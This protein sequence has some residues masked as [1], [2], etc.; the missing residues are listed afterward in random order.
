MDP[1]QRSYSRRSLLPIEQQIID[2]LGLTLDEYWEFCRLADCK[3]KE[4]GEEYALIPEAVASAE[5]VTT[6]TYIVVSLLLAAASTAAA[7][8]LAPRPPS[9]DDDQLTPIRTADV[10]GQ[11]KFAELYAFDSLQDLATLGS[12]IPLVFAKQIPDPGLPNKVIGGIRV[13]SLLLWS[14]LLSKGSHQELKMLTT[15]GLSE[16]AATP[17]SQGL[18]IGDQLL[19]NYQDA[20]YRAYFRNNTADGGRILKGNTFAGSLPEEVGDDIFLAFDP[21]V[22]DKLSPFTSGTR[23]PNS[24]RQFGC[25]TPISNGAPYFLPYNLV[26][27]FDDDDSLKAK[28][29]KING[30]KGTGHSRPFSSRQGMHLLVRIDPITQQE[31]SRFEATPGNAAS[32]EIKAGDRMAFM[33]SFT[34]ED[35]DAFEPHGLDDVNSAIAQR[36]SQTDEQINVGDVF[37]FGSSIIQ[38]TRTSTPEPF[39]EGISESKTYDFV[40]LEPGTGH[41]IAADNQPLIEGNA[42]FGMHLQKLDIATVTNNRS[43]DQTEIGIKSVVFKQVS[44]F[45]NV[46]SEPPQRTLEDYESDGQSFQ[47]GRITTFQTR[48]S[49]FSLQV[50]PINSTD[51]TPFVDIMGGSFFAVRGDTPQPQ[52]NTIR[53][54]HPRGQYEFRLLPRSGT[55]ADGVFIDTPVNSQPLHVLDGANREEIG[56]LFEVSYTGRRRNITNAKVTNKEFLFRRVEENTTVTGKVL[57]LN[58][59]S[60]GSLPPGAA[61]KFTN[62]SRAEFNQETGELEYGVFV[63]VDNPTAPGAKFARWAGQTVELGSQYQYDAAPSDIVDTFPAIK[64][65]RVVEPAVL[66]R[67]GPTPHYYVEVDGDGTLISGVFNDIDV[68]AQTQDP[69]LENDFTKLYRVGSDGEEEVVQIAEGIADDPAGPQY[70]PLTVGGYFGVWERQVDGIRTGVWNGLTVPLTNKAEADLEASDFINGFAYVIGNQ[71]DFFPSIQCQVYE[72]KRKVYTAPGTKRY[73][74]SI[75]KVEAVQ[76]LQALNL[77]KIKLYSFDHEQFPYAYAPVDYSPDSSINGSGSGLKIEASSLGPGHWQWRISDPG[78]GYKKDDRIRFNF[79]DNSFADVFPIELGT[80]IVAGEAR[81]LLNEKDA[82]ADYP[83]Y[84]EEKTSHQEGPEHEVV[85]VNEMIRPD[86]EKVVIVNG[87]EHIGGEARYNDLSLMGI[88]V[89]AGRDWTSMGQLSAYVKQ[90]IVV[91]RLIDDDGGDAADG[92]LT[93]P[94]NN[95]AEI[96]YNLLVSP[97]LGAGKRIPKSTVDRDAMQIAAKFCHANNFTFDGVIGEKA[98]VRDFIFTNAAFNLLDFAIVGGKFSLTPSVPYDSETFK[99]KQQ[100]DIN[101][102]IKAL[103]TDGNMKDMRVSFLPAQERQLPKVTV[104]YR[105]EV[106]NGF[107]S[108]EVVQIRFNDAN[109]GSDNDPEE[110]LDL[111]KF[112]TNP[113]HAETIAMYKLLLRKHSDHTI[114]FKTTPS[115]ALGISAGDYITVISHSTHTNRFNNGSVDAFGG[116]TSSTPLNDS[117]GTKVYFWKPGNTDVK[118]GDLVVTD[119]KTGD[120]AFFG[121]V[122]TIKMTNDQRRVYRV[123]SITID[124]EGLVDIS[125]AHQE[126]YDLRDSNNEVIGSALATIKLDPSQF[127]VTR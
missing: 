106:E 19:R 99:I 24:Q 36:I 67:T 52:Y 3:A 15:L 109:G 45:A 56:G 71:R 35:P 12:I 53:I 63:N 25:H 66:V 78:S 110:F 87:R 122:F 86:P 46:N 70:D 5:P 22:S 41:F 75:E 127:L 83:K 20:R 23:T 40:C 42:P 50:R 34:R 32:L 108:Q 82:I 58:K 18:A 93:G 57:N 101:K 124:D 59:F 118:E 90:G 43:C 8:L 31:T 97:R 11:T 47:L 21:K 7:F 112:C 117:T 116:I 119:N 98:G 80:E 114:D 13:K 29:D 28:R 123:N 103:F 95:F 85:F 76:L 107:S 113:T 27:V 115:S 64:E 39:E 49:F 125:A 62:E 102:N 69:T 111:T 105:L 38:C 94:T 121:T 9:L 88:R 73:F 100:Q 60:Q 79:P 10:R 91:D 89:L 4:R 17:D 72:I 77:Y 120:P 54:T 68:S 96:A 6:T 16:L 65:F 48:Y 37:S 26:Q 2:S 84:Q 14:Q 1:L 126:L 33:N 44:N 55:F 81:E 104:A 92:A 51:D 61:W 74:R 30:P